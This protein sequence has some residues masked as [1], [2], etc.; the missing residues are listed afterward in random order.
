MPD[1]PPS[2]RTARQQF[3]EAAIIAARHGAVTWY[4]GRLMFRCQSPDQRFS[5]SVWLSAGEVGWSGNGDWRET[6]I[7]L[8]LL[9]PDHLARRVPIAASQGLPAKVYPDAGDPLDAF[10]AVAVVEDLRG[11]LSSATLYAAYS[12]WCERAGRKP[13]TQ[14]A[15]VRA[16]R[17]RGWPQAVRMRP[18]GG[19]KQFR[20]WH[21]KRC[22][23]VG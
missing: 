15:F 7:A 14:T 16:L 12:Q 9:D 10:L 19:G 11:V 1:G 20:G 23:F 21:G 8:G 2:K 13:R 17:Q 18:E 5:A 4:P 3:E 22:I 6:G